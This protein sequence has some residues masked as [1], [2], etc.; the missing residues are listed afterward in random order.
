M[1]KTVHEDKTEKNRIA[2]DE[3]AKKHKKEMEKVEEKRK[4]NQKNVTKRICKM[5]SQM[6]KKKLRGAV[7]K[8]RR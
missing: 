1:L 6:E 8:R 3:R 7:G 4:N 5:L 2:T